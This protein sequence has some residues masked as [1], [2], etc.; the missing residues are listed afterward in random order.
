MQWRGLLLALGFLSFSTGT[1]AQSEP[2]DKNVGGP[3]LGGQLV[4][5]QGVKVGDASPGPAW[6]ML[7]DVG[8]G[9]KRDTWNR[10]ELGLELGTG[11]ATFDDNDNGGVKVDL[12]LKM[13]S[14][15]KAGYGYS[16]GD[17]AFGILRVGI[18]MAQAE[19]EG[20]LGNQQSTDDA[21]G[22]AAMV[23]WDAVFPASPTVEFL[24]GASFRV[25]NFNFDRVDD[26]Q[27]NIPSLYGGTR[28][29]DLEANADERLVI[30]VPPPAR[31]RWVAPPGLPG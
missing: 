1:L 12:D 9:I 8:Y 2:V 21:T 31:S 25:M 14:M 23:A 10:I 30:R 5:G 6:L 20:T 27:L 22:T 4:F 3:F 15:I 24:F 26:F 7:A 11:A 13:V 16:L 28:V 29:R 17:H 19:Y 18:G